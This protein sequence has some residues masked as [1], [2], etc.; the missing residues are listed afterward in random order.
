MESGRGENGKEPFPM[1]V[2][3]RTG[4]MR[5]ALRRSIGLTRGL[6]CSG[7]GGRVGCG[8]LFSVNEEGNFWRVGSC[9]EPHS[10]VVLVF[11]LFCSVDRRGRRGEIGE[12]QG[13]VCIQCRGLFVKERCGT[14]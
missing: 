9:S 10:S 14:R 6:F 2:S 8:C 7:A 11:H 5:H 3:Y 1:W 4:D 12:T 13:N